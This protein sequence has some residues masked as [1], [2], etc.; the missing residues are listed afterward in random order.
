L[1]GDAD[2]QEG[3]FFF[4]KRLAIS[5]RAVKGFGLIPGLLRSRASAAKA[6]LEQEKHFPLRSLRLCGAT[7]LHDL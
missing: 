3:F 7:A 1:S 4:V 6:R 5:A 2:K